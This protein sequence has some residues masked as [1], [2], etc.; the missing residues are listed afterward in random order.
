MIRRRDMSIAGLAWALCLVAVAA[1]APGQTV[2]RLADAGKFE[3]VATYDPKTPEGR[4]QA[5]RT[6]L[7]EGKPGEA[8]EQAGA[9]IEEYPSHPRID[10]AH[11]LRGHAKFDNDNYYDALFDYELLIRSYPGSQHFMEALEQEYKIA[12]AFSAGKMRKLWGLPILSAEGEAEELFVRIQERAP[13]SDI[14][15]RASL[16][17]ADY[18]YGAANMSQAVDAY[19]LF[20]QN[21]PQSRHRE[22]VMRRL[23]WASLATFKGPRYDPTGLLEAAAR[24]RQYRQEYPAEAERIGADA[25]LVRIDES[26]ALKAYY[27][28]EWYE[29]KNKPVS[30]V[31]MYRRLV[32][33]YPRTAAAQ[34]AIRRLTQL[35]PQGRIAL[36]K[37]ETPDAPPDESK[38]GPKKGEPSKP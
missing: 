32:R 25:M 15:E 27:T 26:L 5:I 38:N 28:A 13:G 14:G 17:L 2:R 4:I 37:E 24:L 20:L 35:D 7:A 29:R 22:R 33:D 30:A 21:Y 16:A 1:S 34:E 18:F 10:E 23:I 31:Y 6:L 36:T 3:A 11:L 19:D 9:W 12:L 8:E